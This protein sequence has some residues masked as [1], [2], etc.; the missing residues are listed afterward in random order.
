MGRKH[1]LESDGNGGYRVSKSI[2][3]PAL[4]TLIILLISLL[5]Q[6]VW[7]TADLKND[8]SYLKQRYE[9]GRI[10]HPATIKEM[11]ERIVKL[12]MHVETTNYQLKDINKKLDEIKQDLKYHDNN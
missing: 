11:D 10:N 6:G 12:E 4:I 2:A 7:A 8:V 9:E 3:F 5:V 1:Y